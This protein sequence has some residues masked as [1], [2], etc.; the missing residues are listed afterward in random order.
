MAEPHPPNLLDLRQVLADRQEASTRRRWSGRPGKLT[1]PSRQP[2][3]WPG[4][5]RETLKFVVAVLVMAGLFVAGRGGWQVWTDAH[6]AEVLGRQAWSVMQQAGQALTNKQPDQARKHFLQADTLSQQASRQLGDL[7]GLNGRLLRHIPVVSRRYATGQHLLSAEHRLAQAGATV[8]QYLTA[9]TL[10]QP[11]IQIDTDGIITGAI[12]YLPPLIEHY[13][14]WQSV[15][16]N[17]LAALDDLSQVNSRDIPAAERGP[18]L[19]LDRVRPLISGSTN[20]LQPLAAVVSDL[21]ASPEPKDVLVMI[22]NNDELRATGGFTGTFLLVEFSRGTFKILDAPGNGPYALTGQIPQ[23]ILPPQPLLALNPF[24]AFQD[25]NWFLDVPT[26]AHFALDFYRQAR[27]FRPDGVIYVNPQLVENLLT[28]TGPIRPAHYQVDI[29]ADNFIRATEQQVQFGYDKALNNPKQF[30]VDLIPAIIEKL[31]TLPVGQGLSTALTVIAQAD[32]QNLMLF[33]QTKELQKNIELLGWDGGVRLTDGDSL[34][35]VDTNLG[36][37][38]TDRVITERVKGE[39][40]D[41]GT[42]LRHTVSLTRHHGGQSGDPLTGFIN[43]DFIRVYAPANAQ[44]I[45]VTGLTIPDAKFFFTPAEGAT[46]PT[47]LLK[48]EGQV[49]V[50]PQ[51][52]T[53]ITHESGRTVFG[54]W[55]V[56]KPGEKQTVVFTYTTPRPTGKTWSLL[57][58]HQPGAPRRDWTVTYQAAKGRHIRSIIGGGKENGQ[59]TT[60]STNSDTDQLFGVVF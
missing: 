26:S 30:I 23:T 27:G 57:W 56:I 31:R 58:Q 52:G 53:R 20:R 9:E 33:S 46:A 19:V 35:V 51:N 42:T 6:R 5:R 36:G 47:A 55:S 24:W 60:W 43:K 50:D 2:R 59:K 41:D 18:F 32:Q 49:L 17:V 16:H 3:D 34:V 10:S 8:S 12:G 1:R 37:G 11:A 28:I 7:D 40:V 38:K 48:A 15:I 14:A 13:A 4:L 21:L 39:I 22:Q 54:A 44:L 25:T 45:S 29:T